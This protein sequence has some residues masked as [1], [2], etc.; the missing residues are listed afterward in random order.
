MG[1]EPRSGSHERDE[2]DDDVHIQQDDVREYNVG[3]GVANRDSG[4]YDSET[5]LSESEDEGTDGYKKGGYHRVEV[6]DTFKDGR[7]RI[8]KKL[9]WGHFSTV[10]LAWDHQSKVSW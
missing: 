8:V 7:Y 1:P 4:E 5:E 10:W 3:S 6:N 9:G 2:D